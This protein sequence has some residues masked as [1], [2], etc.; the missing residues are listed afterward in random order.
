[1]TILKGIKLESIIHQKALLIIIIS[2]NKFYDQLIDSDIKWYEKIRK[3][4]TGEG[5]DYFTRCL[6]D[7]ECIRNHF[8]LI[9]VDEKN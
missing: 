1:M 2:E 5:E 6:L 4:T 9:P 8:R 7:Y 3:L